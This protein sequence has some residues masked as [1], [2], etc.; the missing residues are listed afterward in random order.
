MKLYPAT[1]SQQQVP[2]EEHLTHFTLMG[3]TFTLLQCNLV[4]S[5]RYMTNHLI[6]HFLLHVSFKQ[7]EFRLVANEL[8]K[9]RSVGGHVSGLP[10]DILRSRE[11]GIKLSATQHL[12]P[13]WEF[14]H[15]VG[16]AG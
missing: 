6:Y 7:T 9:I 11:L 14:C 5:L 15:M 3:L 16:L 13:I 4:I 10:P 2:S 1:N 8:A 12:H